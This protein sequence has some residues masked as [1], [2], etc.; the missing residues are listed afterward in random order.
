MGRTQK[1]ILKSDLMVTER[2]SPL[3][4]GDLRSQNAG[5]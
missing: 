2:T 5:H 3:L 4:P 1:G